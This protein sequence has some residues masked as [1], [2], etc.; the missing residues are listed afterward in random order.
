MIKD[1]IM[2]EKRLM[3]VRALDR[4]SGRATPPKRIWLQVYQGRLYV[5]TKTA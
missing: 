1:I 2:R 4:L 3:E 5:T